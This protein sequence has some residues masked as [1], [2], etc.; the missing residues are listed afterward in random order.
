MITTILMTTTI[1]IIIITTVVIRVVL[2]FEKF[3]ST[4]LLFAAPPELQ[5]P[6]WQVRSD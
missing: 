2:L 6:S 5:E 3:V 1:I 4:P